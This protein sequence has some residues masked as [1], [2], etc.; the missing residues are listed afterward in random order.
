MAN[1]A[2]T[3]PDVDPAA[4]VAGPG[5]AVVLGERRRGPAWMSWWLIA[6]GVYNIVWGGVMVLA[7]VWSMRLLGAA[8]ADGS[9]VLWPQLWACVGMIV[10]VYGIGYLCAARDPLRHWPIVLVG[11]LGKV[12]GPIGFIDAASRG[13]LPWSMG[14]TI[15]SNDL[16]WWVPFAMM[17]WA[18]A[19]AAGAAG[20]GAEGPGAGGPVDLAA[21]LG[22]VRDDA[23]RTLKAITDERPALLVLVRHTGCTFCREAIADLARQQDAIRGGGG[24]AGGAAAAGAHEGPGGGCAIVVVGLAADTKT[25]RAMGDRA[26]L[27]DA[28]YAADPERLLYRALELRRGGFKELFGPRVWARGAA[29]LLAGHGIGRLEGDGF[30]MPGAFVVSRGRVLR[31]FRHASA[32]DRPDYASLACPSM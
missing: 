22:R 17:L 1:T 11:L 28:A 24:R 6:A 8:P 15:L 29:A 27:R 4:S 18:A 32:A 3:N 2:T 9:T 23:G 21:A 13:L 12:F 31:A 26:G 19:R 7:P 25:L 14:V 5:A 16:V 30:Q 10:G 20:A